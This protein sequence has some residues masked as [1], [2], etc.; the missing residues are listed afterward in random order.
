METFNQNNE[1]KNRALTFSPFKILLNRT[2]KGLKYKLNMMQFTM[3]KL[4][5]I[6]IQFTLKYGSYLTK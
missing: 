6:I 3:I 2:K 4:K 1:S 5:S